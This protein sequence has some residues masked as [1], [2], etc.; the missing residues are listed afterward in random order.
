MPCAAGSFRNRAAA[1]A[2]CQDSIAAA[3]GPAQNRRSVNGP[4][5]DES[6]RRAI[7]ACVQSLEELDVLLFLA[8]DPCRYCSP[9]AI[10]EGTRIVP[11]Q[12]SIALEVLASR[13]LLD[14]RIADAVLY[15]LDPASMSS[16]RVVERTLDAAWRTRSAVLDLL[17]ATSTRSGA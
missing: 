2:S 16:R 1:P 5:L 4:T 17:T 15:R 14:V 12:V 9:A 13:N 7:F 6:T 8:R 10:A 3:G 11:S